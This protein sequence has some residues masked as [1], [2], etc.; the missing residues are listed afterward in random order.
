MLQEWL[1]LRGR[2]MSRFQE[3]KRPRFVRMLLEEDGQETRAPASRINRLQGTLD[4]A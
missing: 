1:V 2:G 4:V 3:V